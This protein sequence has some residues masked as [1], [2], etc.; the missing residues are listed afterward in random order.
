[1]GNKNQPLS[2]L[3]IFLVS[4][5]S[6]CA[7]LH[8]VPLTSP[9]LSWKQRQQQ[10]QNLNHWTLRGSI[11]ITY[12]NK[13][14]IASFDWQQVAA[15]YLINIRAPLNLSSA[16]IEGNATQ[17]V[18]WQSTTQ[19]ITARTPESLISK[20]FGW[21]L[22]ISNLKYWIRSLPAPGKTDKIQ[23]DDLHHLAVLHQQGW[24][25]TYSNYQLVNGTDLP[26]KIEIQRPQLKIKLVIRTWEL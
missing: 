1:M 17:V 16:R 15:T 19:K 13:S 18:L 24:V 25:I 5:I 26:E 14:D 11:S 10:L 8:P 7:N 21:N 3:I 2:I 12:G 9:Q 23:L 20:Q 4:V 6:G 22:P